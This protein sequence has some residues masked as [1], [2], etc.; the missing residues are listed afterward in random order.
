MKFRPLEIEMTEA[1]YHDGTRQHVLALAMQ[2]PVVAEHENIHARIIMGTS[3]GALLGTMLRR[4]EPDSLFSQSERDIYNESVET[5]L[6][7]SRSAHESFATFISL[8]RHRDYLDDWKRRL[9]DEYVKYYN[10]I[11][12]FLNP[13]K[14]PCGIVLGYIAFN[15]ALIVFRSG[16]VIRLH[17]KKSLR[18]E[19]LERRFQSN[20]RMELV[21]TKL[22]SQEETLKSLLQASMMK[23]VAAKKMA[24][25]DVLDSKAW[26][27]IPRDVDRCLSNDFRRRIV[28]ITIPVA[29]RT[30][31]EKALGWLMAPAI[32]KGYY[33]VSDPE[34][35]REDVMMAEAQFLGRI[36]NTQIV[37]SEAPS[38]NS[39]VTESMSGETCFV[40]LGESLSSESVTW[41]VLVWER[42]PG[43][44]D[45]PKRVLSLSDHEA[46]DLIV[47]YQ[48]TIKPLE[49][50]RRGLLSICIVIDSSPLLF[51][52]YVRIFRLNFDAHRILCWYWMGF[53]SELT[54]MLG[55]RLPHLKE[56]DI[57]HAVRYTH[58][59]HNVDTDAK[60]MVLIYSAPRIGPIFRVLSP[61]AVRHVDYAEQKTD[62]ILT[63]G[64][65]ESE[66]IARSPF[67]HALR[68]VLTC[69]ESY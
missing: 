40:L 13:E 21:L 25:W 18:I 30:R 47:A 55:E 60:S 66:A 24:P 10:N 64:E 1:G 22:F 48:P 12:L 52:E 14:F 42:E 56:G 53:W 2:D 62:W 46:L 19:K 28:N 65:E 5:L 67:V 59:V 8:Q 50:T 31:D 41:R 7:T 20:F 27:G 44:C 26:E 68:S 11:S 38:Q 33:V 3:D 39:S 61:G 37:R 15:I 43:P 6:D 54:S 4:S 63:G 17:E 34:G 9:P 32:A 16:L 51:R 35:A 45:L 23:V 69:V 36:K 57:P 49:S 58:G 29:N